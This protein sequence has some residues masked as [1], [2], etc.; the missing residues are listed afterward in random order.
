LFSAADIER[1]ARTNA[2][3]QSFAIGLNAASQTMAASQPSYTTYSG[4]YSGNSSYNVYNRYGQ[5]AGNISGYQSGTGYGTATTYNP[6]QTAIANQAI[7]QNAR[8]QMGGVQG[9]LASGLGLASEMLAT[10]TVPPGASVT[11]VVIAKR[12]KTIFLSASV[13]GEKG[14]AKFL[15]K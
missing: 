6:A 1:E 15:V 11:G 13:A 12:S 14:S 5:P 4:S 3:I 10:T 9:Q 8:V 2:A 7:Q